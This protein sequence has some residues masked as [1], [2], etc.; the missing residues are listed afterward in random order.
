M[1]ALWQ[2]KEE[3]GAIGSTGSD[4]GVVVVACGGIRRN[5]PTVRPD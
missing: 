1:L 3:E 5:G 2:G 4:L